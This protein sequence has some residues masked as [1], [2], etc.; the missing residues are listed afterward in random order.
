M[1]SVTCVPPF[2]AIAQ[3]RVLSF[4]FQTVKVKA[5]DCRMKIFD[6]NKSA[7]EPSKKLCKP[8]MNPQKD[9]YGSLKNSWELWQGQLL[10][11]QQ[12]LG[13]L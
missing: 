10:Q 9:C 6:D 13:K 1:Y 4:E 8:Q 5:D 2:F 12:K 3:N 7:N 11:L